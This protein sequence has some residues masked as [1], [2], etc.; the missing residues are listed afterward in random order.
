MS[1]KNVLLNV[2]L[3]IKNPLIIKGLDVNVADWTGL[4]PAT[5]AVTGRHSNQLNY[6]SVLFIGLLS[7]LAMLGF[8]QK[9]CKN[10]AFFANRQVRFAKNAKEFFCPLPIS[11]F[12]V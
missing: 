9:D 12:A 2:V 8:P 1:L 6:Q 5:S 11:I 7:H 3:K 10:N 4:E